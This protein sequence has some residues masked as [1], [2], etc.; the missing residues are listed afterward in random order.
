MFSNWTL[1]SFGILGLLTF[2]LPFFLVGIDRF[3]L[4]LEYEKVQPTITITSTF[5]GF[6]NVVV[7]CSE[8]Y[9]ETFVADQVARQ[10][11]YCF[12]PRTTEV[13]ICNGQLVTLAL[14]AKIMYGGVGHDLPYS[15]VENAKFRNIPSVCA[16]CDWKFSTWKNRPMRYKISDLSCKDVDKDDAEPEL[17]LLF[18]LGGGLGVLI[19]APIVFL[20]GL[21]LDF[22]TLVLVGKFDQQKVVGMDKD[23]KPGKVVF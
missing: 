23:A 5:P 15:A 3:R 17:V 4:I 12:D 8:Q 9:N 20:M 16:L 1:T 7:E 18:L 21:V 6:Q 19:A 2:Y 14:D 13:A 11:D 22:A 10:M